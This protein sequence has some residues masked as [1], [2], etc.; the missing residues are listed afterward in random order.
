MQ[1][2]YSVM[3]SFFSSLRPFGLLASWLILIL[4]PFACVDSEDLTLRGT[5]DVI[6]VDGTITNLAEPQL[7][8]LNRS[9]ADPLTGR[10]GTLPITK[11]TVEIVVDSAQVIPCRETVDGSYQLP[12]KFNG[13]VGHAYQL[14]FTLSDGTRYA[15]TQQIMPAVPPIDRITA[16]FNP[17]SLPAQL[18]D[19]TL[20]Q[21]RGA[22]EV[23]IDWQDPANRHNYYRWDWKLWEKQEW[24]RT[25]I[26]GFYEKY[27]ST[28]T[29]KVYED[30]YA[31]PEFQNLSYNYG[32]YVYYFVNDYPCRTD[33]WEIIYNTDI[34]V[35]DDQYNNGGAI[36][37]RFVAR[38]PYYQNSG[39]LL[40]IRQTSLTQTAYSYFKLFQ[41]QTQNT[42]GIADTPPTALV[43]NVHNTTNSR[44]KV[45][46]YFTASAI[47]PNQYWIDRK[48][49][50]GPFP[51]LYVALN[52]RL[53]S[54][55]EAID[56]N[57]GKGKPKDP[58][59]GVVPKVPTALCVPS[60][61][62]TPYKPNGWRD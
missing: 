29:T 54:R 12:D 34:D 43:G 27:L 55:E 41:A 38:I 19:G 28:D 30:C 40:E 58:L 31:P 60:N 4:L 15:S 3:I 52:S 44:E 35:F 57:T 10:F 9:R 42:G 51:G 22:H 39:C 46:G 16:R 48:D 50:T 53:P 23:A 25:C 49:A 17:T 18:Y 61:T 59:V 32:G 8:R 11:A 62:R 47:A 1:K 24:C 2:N 26:Q 14:R 33:C 45:V 56:P 20:N 5:V 7:I 13:Q 36:K 6:V 37:G 21:Y